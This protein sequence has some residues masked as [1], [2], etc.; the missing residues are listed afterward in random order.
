MQRSTVVMWRPP[1][2]LLIFPVS[3]KSHGINEDGQNPAVRL[4]RR[5][6]R[7]RTPDDRVGRDGA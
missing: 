2:W 5:R 4:V 6:M 1:G 7:A 3:Q